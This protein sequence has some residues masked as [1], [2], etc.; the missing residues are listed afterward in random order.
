MA[1][2]KPSTSPSKM[3]PSSHHKVLALGVVFQ[4]FVIRTEQVNIVF[5]LLIFFNQLLIALVNADRITRH[6]LDVIELLFQFGVC[7]L[8]SLVL[9]V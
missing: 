3:A 8:Q 9:T 1:A 7:V 4:A 5:Q 6:I 2:T